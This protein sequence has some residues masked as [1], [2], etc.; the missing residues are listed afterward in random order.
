VSDL[1]NVDAFRGPT[2]AQASGMTLTAARRAVAAVES[3]AAD[4]RVGLSVARAA[5]AGV[6]T[7]G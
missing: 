1:D 5:D 2:A 3:I 4:M 7:V 6:A